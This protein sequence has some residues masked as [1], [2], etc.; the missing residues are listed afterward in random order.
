MDRLISWPTPEKSPEAVRQVIHEGI[1]EGLLGHDSEFNP[2]T[3][4][5]RIIGVA[6]RHRCAA[7]WWD[8]D[9]ARYMYDSEVPLVAYAGISADK[10]VLDKALGH[11]SPLDR[12]LDPMLLWWGAAPDLSSAPKAATDEGDPDQAALGMMGLW[13]CTSMTHDIQGWKKCRGP[14]QCLAERWPCPEHDELGYCAVDAWAGL[15]DWMAL[16]DEW[17]RLKIPFAYYDFRARLSEYCYKMQLLGV[18]VDQDVIDGLEAAIQSRKATLFPA[19]LSYE[20]KL[21]GK[22]GQPCKLCDKANKS[23]RKVAKAAKIAPVYPDPQG[24]PTCHGTGLQ[25]QTRT[26]L[27]KPRKVWAG[28]FNPNSPKAVI[29]WFAQKGIDLQDRGKPSMGKQVL[30]KALD[31]QLKP[32]GMEFDVKAGEAVGDYEEALPETIDMLLRLTQKTCAG[33]GLDSWFNKQYIVNGESHPR[34]NSCGTSMSRLSSSKPNYQNVP[35]NGFGAEVR[36]A[37]VARPGMKFVRADYS[38]GELFTCLWFARSQRS[39]EGFFEMLVEN[40]KGAFEEAARL[41]SLSQRDIAKSAVHA[42]L[43]GDH[44]VLTK[45]GWISIDSWV[46]QEIAVWNKEDFSIKYEA[47]SGYHDYIVDENLLSVKSRGLQTTCTKDHEFWMLSSGT[48]RGKIYDTWHKLPITQLGP[49]RIPVCGEVQQSE[50]LNYSD[51]EIQQAVAVQADASVYPNRAV[52]HLVKPRK[53]ERLKALFGV[54]GKPCGCH[55]TGIRVSVPFNSKLLLGKE[56]NFSWDITKL[57]L[58]QRQ[59][60]LEEL[61][62][63]DGCHKKTSKYYFSTNKANVDLVQTVAHLSGREALVR[64]FGPGGFPGSVKPNFKISF[65]RRT[66]VS[67]AGMTITETPFKGHVYCFTTSTGAF[68]VRYKNTIHVTGNCNYLEGL[69]LQSARDLSEG[70]RPAERRAGALLVFDGKDLPEWTFRGHYVTF[71]GANLAERLFG[72]RRR[73]SRAKALRIQQVI[74]EAAPELRDVFQRETL[75][76][77]ELS[78]E[79]RLP[80]GHRLP[81]YGRVPE[82]DCKQAVACKGQGG[83]AIYTQ[84]AML[85]F[86]ALGK[87][88]NLQIHDELLGEVPQDWTD[89]ECLDYM[90]PMVEPSD[91]MKGF[92]CPAK[93]KVG[94]NWKDNEVIGTLRWHGNVL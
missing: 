22:P 36:R 84:E 37:V 76:E 20:G 44:E 74:Y 14:A 41:R 52:F 39:G 71:T 85:R 70:N 64:E 93:V 50:K 87:I 88:F 91:V 47:P 35:K 2:A 94:P 31:R 45:D 18:R 60:F 56:K 25:P 49:K 89:H 9:L 13:A 66:F 16:R 86:G 82:D 42:C 6:S 19:T 15:V 1:R 72:D 10:P 75:A 33:K 51:L 38:G 92:T 32:Y 81:L 78:H 48:W 17:D 26:Q 40:S 83:L 79:V 61:L 3:H 8:N 69:V 34:F 57:P 46:D 59:V 90:A 4:Q 53:K 29:E 28:P 73:E 54:E 58:A 12:W 62:L 63:W 24:C 68:L 80:S 11:D 21:K 7:W 55:P 27:T 43:T 23:A 30:L 67:D 77:A 65:N 5:P